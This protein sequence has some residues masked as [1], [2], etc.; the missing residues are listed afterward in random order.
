[1]TTQQ[2]DN[3]TDTTTADA[4]QATTSAVT[5][6]DS[7]IKTQ[8]KHVEKR[9]TVAADDTRGILP[10]GSYRAVVLI[11]HDDE[12]KNGHETFSVTAN[13]YGGPYQVTDKRKRGYG[14]PV[15]SGCCHDVLAAYVPEVA[16][17]I[18]W[19]LVSTD[20][21]MHYP[22]NVLYHAG[23]KDCWGHR[24]GEPSAWSH[25]IQFG[26]NPIKHKV[27]TKF[28]KWLQECKAHP[29]SNPYDLEVIRMD[30][31]E[32]T[33]ETF[34]YAPKYTYGGY[35]HATRWHECPFDTEPEALEFLQA[36]QTANPR[37]VRVATAWSDGKEREFEHARSNAVWPE[38]TDAELSQDTEVLKGVLLSRLPALMAEFRKVV[39][40][41]GFQY[42]G[43]ETA[44]E[45]TGL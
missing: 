23:D 22:A 15:I 26:D 20:G 45:E 2:A 13:V 27:S 31:E 8:Y 24:K 18:K 44:E 35:P 29:G 6:L 39:E 28:W 9:F 4:T 5:R 21:P 11:R 12:C 1:M 42:T 32:R 10:P 16:H 3:M 19:H 14:E 37:F 41:E 43:L 38:A 36:L 17:L 25:A 34:K 30:H 33:G 7:P 40:A